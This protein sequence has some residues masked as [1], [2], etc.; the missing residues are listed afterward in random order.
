[1]TVKIRSLEVEAATSE[2]AAA[3]FAALG[4]SAPKEKGAPE[5]SPL[6]SAFGALAAL[7]APGAP[8]LHEPHVPVPPVH[9]RVRDL[10][11]AALLT[12]SDVARLVQ[13]L[14]PAHLVEVV[15]VE[16][17]E[18]PGLLDTIY[19]DAPE[20]TR[21]FGAPCHTPSRTFAMQVFDAALL[22]V[23]HALP[24]KSYR[25]AAETGEGWHVLPPYG[26]SLRSLAVRLV[27]DEAGVPLRV[28]VA[29]LPRAHAHEVVVAL[30][31]SLTSF[32]E[33]ARLLP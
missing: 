17:I 29:L 1:M 9:V 7:G 28:T 24:C 18:R 5:P 31:A 32:G 19:L 6:A 4:A 10:S 2:E 12:R 25:T 20:G 30:G 21:T 23:L 3:A 27:E 26:P 8:E 11:D 13:R 16:M 33:L 15:F 22:S 14:I